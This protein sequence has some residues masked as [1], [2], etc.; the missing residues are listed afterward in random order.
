MDAIIQ[1]RK[2]FYLSL[3]LFLFQRRVMELNRASLV[4]GTPPATP[5]NSM[6]LT[7]S[8]TQMFDLQEFLSK[9][10]P[11]DRRSKRGTIHEVE[12]NDPFMQE[13]AAEY[14]ASQQSMSQHSKSSSSLHSAH[15]VSSMNRG[16][17]GQGVIANPAALAANSNLNNNTGSSGEYLDLQGMLSSNSSSNLGSV[18]VAST[19]PSK[20]VSGVHDRHSVVSTGG[21]VTGKIKLSPAPQRRANTTYAQKSKALSKRT[22]HKSSG[23]MRE[24]EGRKLKSGIT[25]PLVHRSSTDLSRV[26]EK[27]SDHVGPLGL[28]LSDLADWSSEMLG[29]KRSVSPPRMSREDLQSMQ[30]Q[31]P[32]DEPQPPSY[33][34]QPPRQPSPSIVKHNS[35][36]KPP[37]VP[38][39][40]NSNSQSSQ[41]SGDL[42]SWEDFL[43]STSPTH[44]GPQAAPPTLSE[45]SG[46]DSIWL[47]YGSV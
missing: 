14:K 41:D 38:P 33:E 1:Y 21:G 46:E 24:G 25:A 9:V 10:D 40:N 37:L 22:F 5:R 43:D 17:D 19:P 29:V 6:M 2:K 31:P 15:S 3:C 42:L 30:P 23:N 26:E 45:G 32:S 35:E 47:E 36:T 27:G 16:G 11:G 8:S 34:P 12:E 28:D 13:Q 4:I 39:Q 7:N 44:Q 20:A 18:G